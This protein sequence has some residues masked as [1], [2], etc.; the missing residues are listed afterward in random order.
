MK[1]RHEALSQLEKLI[2]EHYIV[3]QL[4]NPSEKTLRQVSAVLE[5][6]FEEGCCGEVGGSIFYRPEG[7][8]FQVI[9]SRDLISLEETLA[10]FELGEPAD[11]SKLAAAAKER[12][13]LS[14]MYVDEPGS[15][16]S[17]VE[18]IYGMFN[19]FIHEPGL[20]KVISKDGKKNIGRL[21]R[22]VIIDTQYHFTFSELKVPG[23]ILLGVFHVHNDGSEPSPEDL[24]TNQKN[25]FPAV[26]VSAEKDYL[27]SG[28]KLYLIYS[29][30]SHLL[31][32]GPIETRSAR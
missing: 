16:L 5:Q 19:T 4:N 31:Y 24:I 29:G 14:S 6:Q 8:E 9:K 25:P 18:A 13:D 23:K 7:L 10:Q 32:D 12:V 2:A 1:R 20:L 30:A 15:G 17:I 22:E 28:I 26:V 3:P 11:L 21:Y 27:A